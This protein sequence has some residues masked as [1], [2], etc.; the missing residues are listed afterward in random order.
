MSTTATAQK[1]KST[2]TATEPVSMYFVRHS[3]HH[4]YI[5]NPAE[6]HSRVERALA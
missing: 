3:D 2:C 4:L 6:F 5:D 1:Q